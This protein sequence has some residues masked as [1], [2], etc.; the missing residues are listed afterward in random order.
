MRSKF[1][2]CFILLAIIASPNS[3]SAYDTSNDYN[4]ELAKQLNAD[5]Y[6]MRSYV[7]VILKTGPNDTTITNKEKRKAIFSG[8]FSNMGKL[9]KEGKLVLAG[10]FIE[11]G[12]KRGMYIFN[13]VNI[14]DAKALV[15]TD[16]AVVAGIFTAEYTKYYGSAGLMKVNEIHNKIQK[17]KIE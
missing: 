13:V 16:P 4:G 1:F 2:A 10:P 3:I 14:E 8:H 17:V 5:D 12:N 9:A 6:G 7:F 15:E 11:G